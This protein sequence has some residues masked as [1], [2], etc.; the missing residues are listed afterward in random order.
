MKGFVDQVVVVVKG[1]GLIRLVSFHGQS[2]YLLLHKCG[3]YMYIGNKI[4]R[5]K[6]R[7]F[8]VT[9]SEFLSLSLTYTHFGVCVKCH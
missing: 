4:E 9:G 6:E 1:G 8:F 7:S 5:K 3:I 2:C